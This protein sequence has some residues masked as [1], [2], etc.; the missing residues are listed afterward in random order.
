MSEL[1][2]TEISPSRTV[3]FRLKLRI[4]YP[5]GTHEDRSIPANGVLSTEGMP[6]GTTVGFA[7]YPNITRS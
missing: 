3:D 5:D 2:I 7:P 1:S 6:A 4:T